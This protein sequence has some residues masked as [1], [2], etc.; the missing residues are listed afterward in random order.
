MLKLYARIPIRYR[1]ALTLVS[2]FTGAVLFADWIGVVPNDRK[3]LMKGRISLCEALAINGTAMVAS[4]NSEGFEKAVKALVDRNDSLRSVRLVDSEGNVKFETSGHSTFWSSDPDLFASNIAVPIF[5]F[6]QPWGNLQIAFTDPKAE[7]GWA[8][9][10]IWGLLALTV[11]IC[12]LQFS[13]F[14]KRMVS[15]LNPEGAIPDNVRS[16]MD[17]FAE[18]LVI[19]DD[20]ER[21]LIANKQLCNALGQTSDD[22][23]G[24]PISS[25]E[26]EIGDDKTEWP[27][28]EAMREE[29]LISERILRLRRHNDETESFSTF[30][31]TC[32]PFP[33][34]GLMATL[35]DITEIEENKAKLAVALGVAKDA[36]E[37][38]SAFLANM[39]HEIRTPLN[40]VLGFTD[41][42]RRG[43][44]TDSDEAIGHLNMI[45]RSGAHLLELINDILD[46]SKIE[47]G[48]MQCES[49]ETKIDE[50]ILDAVRVQSGRAQEKEIQLNVEFL[51]DLPTTVHCDPTRLRQIITNLLGN[52]IKFTEQG[53]VTVRTE[54]LS[55]DHLASDGS[56]ADS[57]YRLQ[58]HVDD[59]G[60]GMTPEQQE[61]IFDSFVQADSSTTRK[62]GG[63]GL[64][65]SISR[66][67]AEAMGGTLTVSSSLGGGST[68]TV[69][70]PVADS[71]ASEWTSREII[72]G[73]ANRLEQNNGSTAIKRLPPKSVLVVDDGEANRRLIELVLTRAGAIVTCAENG[74]EAIEK[75][76]AGDFQLVFMDMQMP[77][78]DG[79]SATKRLRS[80]GCRVPIV[81]LTG[82]AMKGDREKCIE[83]GCDDFL[84]KPVNLDSL[85]ECC[86]LYLGSAPSDPTDNLTATSNQA[87]AGTSTNNNIFSNLSESKT[88]DRNGPPIHTTIP[89]DDEELREVV[90]NFIDRLDAR[91]SGMEDAV[92]QADFN[93]VR[94]EAHWLKGSGGTVGFGELTNPALKLENAAKVGDAE[95]ALEILQEIQ[96]IRARI[97]SPV[98]P[99]DSASFTTQPTPSHPA[100]DEQRR[101]ASPVHSTMQLSADVTGEKDDSPI[102]CTL[103]LDD[104]DYREIVVDFM[105]R[106]DARLMGMLSMAQTKAF[107]ELENEAHW[108]KGAGGTVGFP[109]LTEPSIA[110]MHAARERKLESCQVALRDILQIRQR[111]V[112]PRTVNP[113]IAGQQ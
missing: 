37:A 71:D 44:V 106:L 82:N 107:D 78:L 89:I 102:H 38:K 13:Y 30:T 79:M 96:S 45:H 16:F 56:R 74:Q 101:I 20:R 87:N 11:P 42:L 12:F 18:G 58:I 47:A 73:R 15:A 64:G 51:T 40:A 31:V 53:A 95:L 86:Q 85:L 60:I 28:S 14:L 35:D 61:K 54:C 103:P 43:L 81:A 22:L 10:G 52:A 3:Q 8:R 48:H 72:V 110:L 66:R 25:L 62:F 104:E 27:W 9:Y 63:T 59:T 91:I 88:A 24:K 57:K 49:I 50:V 69:T 7:L 4:G 36:N 83:G 98:A 19:I 93:T 90:A 41:V 76:N 84:S 112:V 55:D 97:V 77:V 33:G 1:L 109:A 100:I 94:S 108:L 113:T 46:L 70:L 23:F 111:L 5:R 2:I 6:G 26:F 21:I 99:A 29:K 34:Q 75:I 68:F 39:S 67:L 80:A 92:R 32:N 105:N 17:T 65:L